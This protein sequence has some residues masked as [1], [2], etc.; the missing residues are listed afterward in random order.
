M[1]EER[2]RVG[3]EKKEEQGG[4]QM[5]PLRTEQLGLWVKPCGSSALEAEAGG[6]WGQFGLHCETLF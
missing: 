3:S 4:S 1:S 2:G 6:L 5:L